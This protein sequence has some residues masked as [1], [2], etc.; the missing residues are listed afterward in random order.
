MAELEKCVRAIEMD[1][2]LWGAAG[3][4]DVGYGES[5]REVLIAW[6]LRSMSKLCQGGRRHVKEAVASSKEP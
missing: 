1:G 4:E 2:L 3:L 5:L 6:S